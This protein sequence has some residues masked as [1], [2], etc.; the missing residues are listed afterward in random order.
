MEYSSIHHGVSFNSNTGIGA[1]KDSTRLRVMMKPS[2]FLSLALPLMRPRSSLFWL[3]SSWK[4]VEFAPACL[5]IL[6]CDK[7]SIVRHDGRH[8]MTFLKEKLGD[9]Y[10]PVDILIKNPD[11]DFNPDALLET[12]NKGISSQGGH[13]F[14]KGPIFAEKIS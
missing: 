13:R 5:Q 2:T 4:T 7:H 8:R 1:N 6:S 14:I 3:E 10:L 12:L 11:D 9:K